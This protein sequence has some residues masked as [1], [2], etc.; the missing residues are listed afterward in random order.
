MR[1][2][3]GPSGWYSGE[4]VNVVTSERL[5]VQPTNW[6]DTPTECA[7]IAPATLPSGALPGEPITTPGGHYLWTTWGEDEDQVV[8]VVGGWLFGVPE[9]GESGEFGGKV[10]VRGHPGRVMPMGSVEGPWAIA[11]EED[12]CRYEV[13]LAPGGTQAEAVA[14]AGRYS[15]STPTADDERLV[16]AIIQ[17]ARSPSPVGREA[18]PFADDGVW[19]GLAEQLLTRRSPAELVE[20]AAWELQTE[21]FR[22]HVGPFSALDRLAMEGE[23]TVS[24]GPHPHCAS[25]PVPPPDEMADARRL[26]IQPVGT[27]ACLRWWTVD[28]FLTPTGEVQA[29]TLDLWE[30]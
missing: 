9:P 27:D 29:V 11:W 15:A 5:A 30:P 6:P 7:P 17:F 16:D 21:A 25:P 4:L 2:T 3:S 13:Q 1:A 28:L 19:L 8:Q 20:P 12:G 22:G 10:T 14:Y 26:S 23:T 18:I 24:I